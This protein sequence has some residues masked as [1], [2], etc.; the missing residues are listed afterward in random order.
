M[1]EHASS[2]LRVGL[3]AEGTGGRQSEIGRVECL[4]GYDHSQMLIEG[5]DALVVFIARSI[6]ELLTRAEESAR[7][8]EH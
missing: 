5:V 8:Q 1:S 4:S 7:I 6:R 2:C 3:L